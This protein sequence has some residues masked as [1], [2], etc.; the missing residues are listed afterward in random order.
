LNSVNDFIDFYISNPSWAKSLVKYH[1]EYT[2]YEWCSINSDPDY[3]HTIYQNTWLTSDDF[4]D[5][6]LMTQS[7]GDAVNVTYFL[8]AGNISDPL[9]LFNMDPYFTSVTSCTCE[10]MQGQG[11]ANR[12]DMQNILSTNFHGV[13]G[14]DIKQ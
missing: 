5:L 2:Y 13:T 8:S 4:D 12:T 6:L 3:F 7:F 1:P 9:D 14:M 11:Y 10:A